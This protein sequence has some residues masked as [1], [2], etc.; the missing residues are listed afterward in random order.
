M[1][2]FGFMLATTHRALGLKESEVQEM[3]SQHPRATFSANTVQFEWD[4][5]SRVAVVPVGV[6]AKVVKW[7]NRFNELARARAG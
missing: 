3:L 4:G 6:R 2:N 7:V 1:K 5:G